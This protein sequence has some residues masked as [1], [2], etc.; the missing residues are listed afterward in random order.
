MDIEEDDHNCYNIA[1]T[2]NNSINNFSSSWSSNYCNVN[3][4]WQQQQL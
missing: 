1:D 2:S 4:Q 3:L